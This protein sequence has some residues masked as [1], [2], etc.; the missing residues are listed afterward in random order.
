MLISCIG[1][2]FEINFYKFSETPED[3]FLLYKNNNESILK[4][5][6]ICNIFLNMVKYKFWK[7]TFLNFNISENQVD[8]SEENICLVLLLFGFPTQ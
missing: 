5:T 8:I 4:V 3:K 1:K 2:I 6:I 7:H